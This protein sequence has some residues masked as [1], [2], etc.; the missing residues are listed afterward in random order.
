MSMVSTPSER[1]L[2][3]LTTA[4]YFYEPRSHIGVSDS[5]MLLE[6]LAGAVAE[7]ITDHPEVAVAYSG[8][9]DSTILALLARRL[10]RVMCYTACTRDSHDL[11]N[12]CLHGAMDGLEVA[13]L[14]LEDADIERL[15]GRVSEHLDTTD[16]VRVGYTIPIIA[17]L[18]RASENAV[19]V[20]NCA[21]ELFAGYAKYESSD[22]ADH[23]MK[24][25]LEK[26]VRELDQLQSLAKSERKLLSAPFA[27]DKVIEAAA[28]LHLSQKIGP[29]G[30]KL[31]LRRIATNLG[32]RDGNR[33]KKAAQYSSGVARSMSR[34]AK[35]SGLTQNAW[36]AAQRKSEGRAIV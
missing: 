32:A 18:E 24:L 3:L 7:A 26:A 15:A 1:W 6:T 27:S 14:E 8:G 4:S 5:E 10:A 13:I 21:D 35:G 17:V 9:L 31:I 25:D 30:R 28:A 34:L 36:I 16:P 20:G 12:A 2:T 19:L 33:P 23:M 22:A 11:R 29:R